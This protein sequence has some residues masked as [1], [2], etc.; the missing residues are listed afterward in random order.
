MPSNKQHFLYTKL[1][2]NLSK[3]LSAGLRR[4][5]ALSQT[6]SK[7]SLNIYIY[8]NK[9]T[10]EPGTVKFMQNTH[11]EWLESNVWSAQFSFD[12]RNGFC[13]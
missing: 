13:P 10:V 3:R 5:Q 6:T 12:L 8:A 1:R 7:Q 9:C 4:Y 2:P 11:L